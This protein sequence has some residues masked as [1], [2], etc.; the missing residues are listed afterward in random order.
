MGDAQ[1]G[2]AVLHPH[3]LVFLRV[4]IIIRIH[5]DLPE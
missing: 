2:F 3:P 1:R 5:I 4:E